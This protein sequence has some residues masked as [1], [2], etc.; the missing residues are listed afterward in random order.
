MQRAWP[1]QQAVASR[2]Y[3]VIAS[4]AAMGGGTWIAVG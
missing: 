1:A 2:R 3:I 4:A